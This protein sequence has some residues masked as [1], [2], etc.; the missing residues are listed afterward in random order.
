MT[1]QTLGI[2]GLGSRSTLFYISRLNELY[3]QK[4]GGYSTCPF[5]MVNSNLDLINPLLPERSEQLDH[6]MLT[7]IKEL[8]QIETDHILFPNITLH[9]TI[10]HIGTTK[11]VLHPVY[12]T[13]KRLKAANLDNVVL[14]GSLH[15]MQSDY[16]QLIFSAYGI[17]IILPTMDEMNFID[18]FRRNIYNQIE[19]PNTIEQYDLLLEKYA[20]TQPVVIGCTELSIINTSTDNVWDMAHIQLEEAIKTQE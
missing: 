16:I 13:A 14:F 4:N 12:L 18:T 1:K 8:E 9:E 7:Y 6:I 19:T 17:E 3:N 20:S 10:D 15:T 11:N 2:L 5:L